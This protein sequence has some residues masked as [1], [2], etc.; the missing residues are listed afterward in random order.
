MIVTSGPYYQVGRVMHDG[1]GLT[2][3][4]WGAPGCRR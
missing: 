4:N 3:K 2:P 1:W